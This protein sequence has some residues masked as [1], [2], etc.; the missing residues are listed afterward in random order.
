VTAENDLIG[1]LAE[2]VND[3]LAFVERAFPWGQP[4]TDL[5][6]DQ[7]PETWQRDLLVAVRDGLMTPDRAIQLAV[8][9][10]HGVGKSCLVSWL[11]LWAMSTFEDTKVV[12]TANTET[13]LRTKT[14]AELAKWYRL[15]IGRDMFKFTATCLY[16]ADPDHEKTWRCD[17][18]PW[19]ERNTEAFAGL[20]NFG[21]RILVVFDEASSIP[22][23]IWETAEGALTDLNTQIIWLVCGNPTRPIGRFRACWEAFARFWTRFEVDSRTVRRT[24]KDQIARWADAWGDD[25]DFF[26]VRVLGKFPRVGVMEFISGEVVRQAAARE[27]DPPV[28]E[29][30]VLGLDVARFGDDATVLYFRKGRDGRSIPPVVLRGA[31]TMAVAGR[32]A[33]E[34]RRLH[35]DAI[36]VDGTGVGGGVID[37]LRQLKVPA[38]DIQFAG[39]ADRSGDGVETVR[40]ANKRAEMWGF[41]REW[42]R[43]GAIVD[44]RQLIEELATPMYG[45]NA[46]N[47]IQLERKEDI[48]KRGKSS[49]DMADA[50]ALTFA[51]EVLPSADAGGEHRYGE[52]LVVVDYD[53]LETYS[54]EAA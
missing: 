51:Y 8:S 33:E 47:E 20:H 36:F 21:K 2:T 31:D 43:G 11:I 16:S 41:M 39:K 37:R 44:D 46:R 40:Y 25:S 26:R 48:K 27:V 9:S 14:W 49:P 53:P 22:D 13:Q 32:A 34:F 50:L 28:Y 5:V 19:S 30:L 24:N 6:S 45:Y 12:V 38:W 17:M 7:G 29:A 1:L 15:F 18:V 54:Q 35:A 52:P 10:G 42:L 23:I 3:P 4:G